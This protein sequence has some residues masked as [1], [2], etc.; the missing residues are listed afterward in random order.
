MSEKGKE[1]I[2]L[3]VKMNGK[4]LEFKDIEA[5]ELERDIESIDN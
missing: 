4:W 2:N 1:K 3:K 5:I